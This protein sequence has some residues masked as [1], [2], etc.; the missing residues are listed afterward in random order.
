MDLKISSR[1]EHGRIAADFISNTRALFMEGSEHTSLLNL[2]KPIPKAFRML[3]GQIDTAI[4]NREDD[5]LSL[6]QWLQE[7]TGEIQTLSE[8]ATGLSTVITG[9]EVQ[10]TRDSL[11]RETGSM[12]SIWDKES[13]RAADQ[14]LQQIATCLVELGWS[15][16]E[17][18]RVVRHLK[19]L[20]VTTRIESARLGHAGA[21][22]ST[23]ADDVGG[24]ADKIVQSSAGIAGRRE[25]LTQF[26]NCVRQSMKEIT[27]IHE[28]CSRDAGSRLE[29]NIRSLQEFMGR[30]EE[31]TL[32]VSDRMREIAESTGEIVSALQFQDITRQQVEHV[33][34]ALNDVAAMV[35]EKLH[36]GMD[37]PE[38]LEI[39]TWVV[40][41]CRLQVKQMQSGRFRL[42]EAV[43]NILENIRKVS[44]SVES[45]S[46]QMIQT[47]G[48]DGNSGGTTLAR[49]GSAISHVA[50]CMEDFAG[51]G[52]SIG[53]TMQEFAIMVEDMSSFVTEI[54]EVGAEIEL[55]ALNASVKASHAG[56]EGA[57]LGVLAISIQGLSLQARKHTVDVSSRLNLMREASG[58]LLGVSERL[59]DITPVREVL[60]RQKAAM[61][62][63]DKVNARLCRGI[64]EMSAQARHLGAELHRQADGIAFH[65]ELD[66][67]LSTYGKDIESHYGSLMDHLPLEDIHI[68]SESL[69][70]IFNRYTM[71]AERAIHLSDGEE[72]F[73]GDQEEGLP[74]DSEFGDN[75]ELF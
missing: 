59:M 18:K 16:A 65:K 17:F 7:V 33:A 71:D 13:G 58:R 43:E 19:A 40:D 38:L 34:E 15:L 26:L 14:D 62:S 54:Q 75:I 45:I 11:A 47:L 12:V 31:N 60:N 35:E 8:R 39:A 36:A 20:R 55:I 49:V 25:K 72:D 28:E 57:A 21:A 67:E 50:H 61:E 6:G 68:Q 52:S 22:F 56:S 3:S 29:S 44:G 74:D 64:E 9:E 30:S 2:L 73:A 46:Y 37:R 51:R 42:V 5:F 66:K 27:D 4:P 63:L 1:N 24:L 69:R 70:E 23:L 48:M 53:K 41:V 10:T 32:I